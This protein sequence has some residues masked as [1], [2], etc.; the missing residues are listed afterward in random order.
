ML[1]GGAPDKRLATP[2]AK[3]MIHQGSAGTKGAPRDM[4]VQLREVLSTTKRMAEIIA[5]HSGRPLEQ[6]EHDI[7]RAE[8][9][10]EYGLIDDILKPRRG[11]SAGVLAGATAN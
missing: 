7:D 5:Y 1:A 2:N 8:E 4:E 11:V 9:A 3:I 10:R 6:V